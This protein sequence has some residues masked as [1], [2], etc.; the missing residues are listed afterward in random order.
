LSKY[1]NALKQLLSGVQ[2]ARTE[3]LALMLAEKAAKLRGRYTEAFERFD[4]AVR[5]AEK[6]LATKDE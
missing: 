2:T 4:K 1:K 3:L 5:A 6:V